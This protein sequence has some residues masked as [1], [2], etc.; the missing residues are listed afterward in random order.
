MGY[1]EFKGGT[2]CQ[3]GFVLYMII[4]QGNDE[5][6]ISMALVILAKFDLFQ[7]NDSLRNRNN[8]LKF[9]S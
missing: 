3:K 7:G 1:V 6:W 9:N 8:S 5:V 2:N 4:F